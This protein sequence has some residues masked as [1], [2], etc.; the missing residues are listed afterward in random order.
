MAGYRD[1]GSYLRKFIE[2]QLQAFA[3]LIV[4]KPGAG[5]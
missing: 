3:W 4:S 1:P 5:V 2:V